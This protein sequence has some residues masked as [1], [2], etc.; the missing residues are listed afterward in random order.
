MNVA[1][2]KWWCRGERTRDALEPDNISLP[3]TVVAL[4]SYFLYLFF[5]WEVKEKGAGC[6]LTRRFKSQDCCHGCYYY[7]TRKSGW[8]SS[9]T[10]R[11]LHLPNGFRLADCLLLLSS[12]GLDLSLEMS[13]KLGK[14]EKRRFT[15]ADLALFN[16]QYLEGGKKLYCQYFCPT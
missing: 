8:D 9:S 7:G 15:R 16:T 12:C 6:L 4:M 5:P 14:E 13:K 1:I 2:E 11:S 10:K 3:Y